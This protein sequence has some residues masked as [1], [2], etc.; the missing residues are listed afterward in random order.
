M[1]IHIVI[2][3]LVLLPSVILHE[4][5]HG[6]VAFRLGDPTAKERGRLSLNPFK[7]ISWFGTVLMPLLLSLFHL[8]VFGYA[9][10]VPIDPRYFENPRQGMA[11]VALAGPAT[12]IVIALLC[13]VFLNMGMDWIQPGAKAAALAFADSGAYFW[14]GRL[15]FY[16]VLAYQGL[17][18]NLVLVIFNA[19]P[20]PPLDGSRVVSWLLP[21]P[22]A[23]GYNR[24]EPYG[25]AIVMALLY[26]D[27]F[28]WLF[29]RLLTPLLNS[30]VY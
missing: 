15:V 12:N 5:A 4:V 11:L 24:I 3:A 22:L 8:P 13:T 30:L 17:I 14:P 28:S 27:F 19:M 23:R 26:F 10:P 7:H 16:G 1:L 29:E 9:K 6:Y 18:I 20:V 25:M 21:D 2:A